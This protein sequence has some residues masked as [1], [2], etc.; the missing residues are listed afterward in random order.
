VQTVKLYTPVIDQPDTAALK[1]LKELLN[2]IKE[3]DVREDNAEM[4][5]AK[6]QV[7]ALK[8]EK[9]KPTPVPPP[10]VAEAPVNPYAAL[11]QAAGQSTGTAGTGPV[12]VVGFPNIDGSMIKSAYIETM[13]D[14]KKMFNMQ[15]V[16]E[17]TMPQYAL[18][19]MAL[20]VRS[21]SDSMGYAMEYV[22]INSIY[23][24]NNALNLVVPIAQAQN[25]SRG[26]ITPEQ[27][28]RGSTI[29][30]N[31]EALNPNF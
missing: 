25:Y 11:M 19:E 15:Y 30:L 9:E 31:G 4:A 16:T 27:M 8:K 3:R 17:N 14:G 2:A 21:I 24:G 10:G 20:M 6:A 28:L 18:R 7:E 1:K 12:S 23:G 13:P 29:T 22:T 5:G 26:L